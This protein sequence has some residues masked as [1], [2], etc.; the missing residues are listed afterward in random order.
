MASRRATS[1]SAGTAGLINWLWDVCG[2]PDIMPFQIMTS[3]KS[4]FHRRPQRA[5][6]G[7][8]G[9]VGKFSERRLHVL[10]PDAEAVVGRDVVHGLYVAGEI[11]LQLDHLLLVE[12]VFRMRL[13]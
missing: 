11:A 4:R 13:H 10:D 7:F 9:A 3:Q 2:S 5:G 1:T 8:L 6:G 12:L